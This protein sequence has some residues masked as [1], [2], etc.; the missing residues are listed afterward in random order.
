MST[1]VRAFFFTPTMAPDQAKARYHAL[2]R[3]LHPDTPTGDT[4]LAQVLNVEYEAFAAG[5]LLPV[6]TH[7]RVWQAPPPPTDRAAR[8]R[9]YAAEYIEEILP[10]LPGVRY[11]FDSAAEEIIARGNTYP[12]KEVLKAEGFRWDGERRIWWLKVAL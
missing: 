2:V 12:V 3:V 1:T 4:A 7:D 9:A 11:I 5:R 10:D 6:G 8:V